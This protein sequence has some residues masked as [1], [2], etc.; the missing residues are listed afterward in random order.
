[1]IE[2]AT[3]DDVAAAVA[4]AA[5]AAAA[6]AA[7]AAA[8]TAGSG[9]PLMLKRATADDEATTSDRTRGRASNRSLNRRQHTM[10]YSP[11]SQSSYSISTK[12]RHRHARQ[13]VA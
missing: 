9:R 5:A 2:R 13:N 10:Q 11:S 1:M 12:R 8:A 6:G 4:A 7:G 3:A